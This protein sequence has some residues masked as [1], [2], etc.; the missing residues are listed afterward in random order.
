MENSRY[1]VNYGGFSKKL[2]FFPVE[3]PGIRPVKIKRDLWMFCRCFRENPTRVLISPE[4]KLRRK[5]LSTGS[6]TDF[7]KIPQDMHRVLTGYQQERESGVLM[8][9][10]QQDW[11][12]CAVV[13]S[14]TEW[15]I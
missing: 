10:Y 15:G 13:R 11:E 1:P 7:H 3:I 5:K 9:D 2:S 8:A 14:L 12:P 6:S 4:I